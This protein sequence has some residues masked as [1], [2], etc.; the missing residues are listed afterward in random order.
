MIVVNNHSHAAI[1]A[2]YKPTSNRLTD[3]LIDSSIRVVS[4]VVEIPI[5]PAF[6]G[7]S[8]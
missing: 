3:I 1:Y 5:L 4:S 7:G 2:G 6:L 8:S